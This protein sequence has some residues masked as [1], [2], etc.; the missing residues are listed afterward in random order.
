MVDKLLFPWMVPGGMLFFFNIQNY[1]VLVNCKEI[2]CRFY[3]D[4]LNFLSDCEKSLYLSKLYLK[5]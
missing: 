2:P 3:F 4:Q 5:C 1:F